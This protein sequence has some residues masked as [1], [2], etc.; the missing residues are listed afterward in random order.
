M[1]RD[2]DIKKIIK[3][4][5]ITNE[6]EYERALIADRKLRLLAKEAPYF[7]SLRKELRDLIEKYELSEWNNLGQITEE[8]LIES[9]DSER[10]AEQE[11]LFLEARK[12][13]IRKKLKQ[14]D[15]TQ[16]NLAAILGHK[17]K[18]YMSELMNGIR[19]F[20]LRDL[21]IINQLLK[22]KMEN[23]IPV[24]L[25]PEDIQGVK[26]AIKKLDKPQLK[27]IMDGLAVN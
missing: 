19:P 16:E 2:I 9:D 20:T 15:L 6:L 10:I 27:P 23:L 12:T 5:L 21:I 24:F 3:K 13:L 25:T 1:K 7:K 8:K 18:T 17:S 11:R 22:I 4:G 14:F 26:K